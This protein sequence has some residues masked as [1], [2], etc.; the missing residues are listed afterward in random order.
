MQ[1]K[2]TNKTI[3]ITAIAGA[4]F[5]FLG[6]Y[7]HPMHADPNDALAA[8]TEYAEDHHWVASHFIQLLGA[9]LMVIA[10]VLVNSVLSE[11]AARVF[12]QIGSIG[13]I[14]VLAL[15]GA[16]QAVDGV[17][18]KSMVNAWAAASEPDK[19]VLFY[20]AF[21]VRQIEIGL[22]SVS[23]LI[24]GVTVFTMGFALLL[25]SSY[26]RWSG[27]LGILAGIPTT[28]A[29]VII[30]YTGF[31]ELS[32]MVNMPASVLLLVWMISLGVFSWRR[33]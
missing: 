20:S 21:G 30:G 2:F 24:T 25:D 32:M 6:T 16:L 26:P 4:L 10:L 15:T 22:A 1:S 18:L 3:A 29:G 27:V 23:S 13:A 33:S 9:A 28:F 17:A 31:S 8:F 14:S 11:P 7:L 12:G 5:L 19:S